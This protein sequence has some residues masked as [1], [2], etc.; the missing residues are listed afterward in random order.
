MQAAGIRVPPRRGL[1][2]GWA[3]GSGAIEAGRFVPPQFGN[4]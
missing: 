3:N 1:D 2:I 4:P